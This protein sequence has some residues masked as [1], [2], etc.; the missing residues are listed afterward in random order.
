MYHSFNQFIIASYSKEG[1]LHFQL[2]YIHHL[3]DIN[4]T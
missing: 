3:N 1:S 4:V 2:S